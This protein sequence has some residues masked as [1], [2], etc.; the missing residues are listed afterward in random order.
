MLFVM[1]IKLLENCFHIYFFNIILC[2]K[3]NY[4]ILN[5]EVLN[6]YEII[7][8]LLLIILTTFFNNF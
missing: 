4:I 2:L 6:K 1:I 5:F 3:I 7:I 8:I